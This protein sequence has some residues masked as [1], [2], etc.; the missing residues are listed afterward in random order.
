M[1]VLMI[2]DLNKVGKRGE[3]VEISDGYA[4]NFVIPKG[5]GKRWNEQTLKEFQKE[6][7][8]EALRQEELRK[9]ALE[10]KSKLDSIELVYEA[11][12]GKN[13]AMIGTVSNKT[14]AEDLKSKYGIVI[15]KRK[16]IDHYLVN[17]FGIF[18]CLYHRCRTVRSARGY[19]ARLDALDDAP[20]RRGVLHAHVHHKRQYTSSAYE[21]SFERT[22]Y[23]H[24]GVQRRMF[25]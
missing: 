9:E 15:D 18:A 19:M 16:F 17:C 21:M 6:K 8:E 5:Y 1:K 11:N 22:C 14:I 3:I 7:E 25:G 23:K 4:A 10:M 13:G 24:G 20:V 12:I 2:K